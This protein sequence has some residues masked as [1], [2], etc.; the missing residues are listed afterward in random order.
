MLTN[1]LAE[2]KGNERCGGNSGD[3][4]YWADFDH[5]EGCRA[6][7]GIL[8]RCAW[9][10]AAVHGAKHGVFRLWWG[11]ADAGEGIVAGIRSSQLDFLFSSGGYS[12]GVPAA[13]TAQ[14]GDRSA[15]AAHRADANARSVDDGVQG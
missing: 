9:I 2:V 4:E 15:A 14:R 6:G 12:G 11:A 7:N 8:S 5:R 1:L 3:S 10:A 13:D